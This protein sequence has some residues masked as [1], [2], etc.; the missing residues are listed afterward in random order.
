MKDIDVLTLILSLSA[1][2]MAVVAMTMNPDA[3]VLLKY[4]W[5]LL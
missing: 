4:V 1:L 5:S 3:I 2:T